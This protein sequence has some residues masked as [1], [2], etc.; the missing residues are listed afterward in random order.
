MINICLECSKEF[1]SPKKPSKFCS[2]K[3]RTYNFRKV[4]DT[5]GRPLKHNCPYCVCNEET[6]Y[7]P[8]K[9]SAGSGPNSE[10]LSQEYVE[11]PA[12]KGISAKDILEQ[13]KATM[14][15]FLAENPHKKTPETDAELKQMEEELEG[16]QYVKEADFQREGTDFV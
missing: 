1:E 3:C 16:P 9:V 11:V 2:P 6:V 12:F 13:Q 15:K 10:D 4:K 7:V 14:E 8:E 5:S